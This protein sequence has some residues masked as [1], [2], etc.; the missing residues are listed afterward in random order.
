VEK[1]LTPIIEAR[2]LYVVQDPRNAADFIIDDNGNKRMDFETVP[3]VLILDET[4][5]G[6]ELPAWNLDLVPSYDHMTV[7]GQDTWTFAIRAIIDVLPGH[8]TSRIAAMAEAQID[9]QHVM[10]ASMRKWVKN[11]IASQT[12]EHTGTAVS[13]WDIPRTAADIGSGWSGGAPSDDIGTGSWE[14]NGPDEPRGIAVLGGTSSGGSSSSSGRNTRRFAQ[15][16][17]V[18]YK[19]Y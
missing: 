4:H 18:K 6:K 1:V 15:T 8:F 3:N 16:G 13:G 11:H 10:T 19:H 17:D 7:H 9:K 12:S 14:W 2:I 5:I